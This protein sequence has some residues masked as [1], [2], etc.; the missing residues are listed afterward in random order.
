MN[1]EIGRHYWLLK[2]K[3]RME[4]KVEENFIILLY[5]FASWIVNP[6]LIENNSI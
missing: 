6:H 1:D 3:K 4:E 5:T 2:R